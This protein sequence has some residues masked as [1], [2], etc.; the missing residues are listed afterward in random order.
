MNGNTKI[1][2]GANEIGTLKIKEE[3]F[4]VLPKKH[5]AELGLLLNS[6]IEGEKELRQGK[7]R[8][9]REFLTS[10]SRRKQ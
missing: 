10:L 4:V 6:V 2:N 9:F 3:S 8:S 7:T 1:K 5:W